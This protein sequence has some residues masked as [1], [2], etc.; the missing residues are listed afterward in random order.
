MSARH[1]RPCAGADCTDTAVGRAL[2]CPDCADK[3]D[4]LD[5]CVELCEASAR[6]LATTDATLSLLAAVAQVGRDAARYAAD[7][8][9]AWPP[10]E[11]QEGDLETIG[12]EARSRGETLPDEFFREDG[13]AW[14][15]YCGAA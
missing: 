14:S 12:A 2:L 4:E 6:W 10:G 7:E 15:A 11:W 8:G 3:R 9:E 5:E 13:P 1:E